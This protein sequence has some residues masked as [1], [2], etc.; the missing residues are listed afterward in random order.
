[1]EYRWNRTSLVSS[2]GGIVMTF[3]IRM[4]PLFHQR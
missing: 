2:V 1:M 3:P 4:G